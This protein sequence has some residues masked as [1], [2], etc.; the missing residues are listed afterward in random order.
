MTE[1]ELDEATRTEIRSKAKA[2]YEEFLSAVVGK[3]ATVPVTLFDPTPGAAVPAVVSD[4]GE[5]ADDEP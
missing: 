3:K 1:A 4:E 5:V 2:N